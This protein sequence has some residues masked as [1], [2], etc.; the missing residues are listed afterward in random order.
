MAK[1]QP[2]N[3]SLKKTVQ[4]DIRKIRTVRKPVAKKKPAAKQ[5]SSLPKRVNGIKKTTKKP[6]RKTVKRVIPQEQHLQPKLFST[7][8]EKEMVEVSKFTAVQVAQEEVAQYNL[9]V[10]YYD[11]R[12][13][14]LSR[15]PWWIYLYWDI[16]EGR[17]SEVIS[18]IPV[19]EREGLRWILRVY[20]VSGVRD[21]R[22]N[23]ANSSF[24]V[25]INFDAANWYINV[26]R[27]ECEWCV[28]IGLVT[29]AGAFYPVA[30][31]NIIKTPYFGISDIID[32]EWATADEDYFKMVGLYDLGK[33]SLERRK[34]LEE[35]VKGQ[36]SSGAFSGGLSSLFSMR[37]KPKQRKFFLEVWTELILY[38]R[39]E[40]TADVSVCGKKIKLRQD[41]TFS[42]RYALPEG[43]FRYDVLATSEDK[44]D[45]LKRVP[46]V[47]RFE[48][49]D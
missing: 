15:D 2:R 46:A 44:I 49:K 35:V 45:T 12:I 1:K 18:S 23:N 40:P 41:G 19:H 9:P 14:A 32:E 34:K 48:I 16:T 38:G 31:S 5:N 25:G 7:Q 24:D 43:D 20:D 37:E 47:K 39:T 42:A 11:N 30:R 21:F 6:E 33:S 27:P 4:S 22:G 10:R 17:I 13:V 36:I 29:I 28:E 26:N 8:T 3:K